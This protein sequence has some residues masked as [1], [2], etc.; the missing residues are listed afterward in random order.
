MIQVIKTAIH[1]HIH[2]SVNKDWAGVRVRHVA[3]ASLIDSQD[4]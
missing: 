3:A 1:Y 4:R 2:A